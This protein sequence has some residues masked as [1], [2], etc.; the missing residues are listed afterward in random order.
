MLSNVDFC[1]DNVVDIGRDR[2]AFT[3]D[4]ELTQRVT[5]QNEYHAALAPVGGVVDRLRPDPD[6]SELRSSEALAARLFVWCEAQ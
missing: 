3:G 6:W 2:L 5:V 4:S 1:P